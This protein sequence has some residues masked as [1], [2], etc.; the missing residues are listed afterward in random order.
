MDQ[1]FVPSN[2]VCRCFSCWTYFSA[3]PGI[4]ILVLLDQLCCMKI[5][6][7]I[8]SASWTNA[9]SHLPSAT[10]N[11]A[12]RRWISSGSVNSVFSNIRLKLGDISHSWWTGELKTVDIVECG[13]NCWRERSLAIASWLFAAG[14]VLRIWLCRWVID[15]SFLTMAIDDVLSLPS[16]ACQHS[17]W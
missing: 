9:L 8:W 7:L 10:R 4:C 2:L 14:W 1:A 11:S 5:Y 16:I 17:A 3:H 6:N 15:G 13:R 12:Y